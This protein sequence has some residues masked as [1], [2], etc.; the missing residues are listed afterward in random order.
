M[1]EEDLRIVLTGK[2][3]FRTFAKLESEVD[4]LKKGASIIA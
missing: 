2:C 3:S 4:K 1:A